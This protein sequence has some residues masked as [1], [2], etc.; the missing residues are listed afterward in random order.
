MQMQTTPGK[1]A[2]YRWASCPTPTGWQAN[3]DVKKGL[4]DVLGEVIYT[5][6]LQLRRI[7]PADLRLLFTW[8]N[9]EKAFGKYLTPERLTRE[10]IE[11]QL[12]S[13]LL[14]SRHDKT[15][16]IEKR[17]PTLPIG[18]I[19]YWLKQDRQRCAVISVKIA[20]VAQRGQGFGTEAQKF[21][22]IQ[23]FEQ[24]GVEQVEMVTDIDNVAQQ[25]CLSKLG[26]K[27]DRS[28]TYD[29]HQVSRTGH[30]YRLPRKAY[31]QALIYRYHYE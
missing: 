14:W 8:S 30:L 20:D 4:K 29:D 19:H 27:V 24:V 28:L 18:T 10:R 7:K 21:L 15:L 6:R 11:E 16:L 23:L 3:G 5:R 13:G 31:E 26:F 17:E 1:T 12:D 22:I 2:A 9:D 25:R